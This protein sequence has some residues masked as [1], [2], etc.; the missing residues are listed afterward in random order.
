MHFMGL[1]SV[2]KGGWFELAPN[3]EFIVHV[4][5]AA[6]RLRPRVPAPPADTSDAAVQLEKCVPA[7]QLKTLQRLDER[8]S[9][10]AEK[11]GDYF[12]VD[13][14]EERAPF[15]DFGS[16]GAARQLLGQCY[17]PLE[18]HYNRRPCTW[19][20]VSR[21]DKTQQNICGV[22]KPPEEKALFEV[23]FLTCKFG[24]A[25]M[26]GPVR[27]LRIAEGTTTQSEVGLVWDPPE[28]DGGTPLRGY[29]VEARE[30]SGNGLADLGGVLGGDETPRTASAPPSAEPS[31]TLR[32]LHGNTAYVFCVWA[33]SEAG[34]GSGSEVEGQT[35]AVEPGLCGLPRLVPGSEA[36][37]E[38]Q[39]VEWDPPQESGGALIVAYRVWLRPLF[40]N[41]SGQIFPAEGWIDLGFFEH[42]GAQTEIQRSPLRLDALPAC[43]GCLC[44]LSALNSSGHTGPST[45]E[46]PIIVAQPAQL[47]LPEK[48][49]SLK[50]G[51]ASLGQEG[52]W[53]EDRA[54]PDLSS[55]GRGH[56]A[57]G[58]ERGPE[59]G[60]ASDDVRAVVSRAMQRAQELQE[61]LL[62][63]ENARAAAS[64]APHLQSRYPPVT[65][66]T[67]AA[68]SK[69][70]ISPSA[71]GGGYASSAALKAPPMT[72]P[73]A[74]AEESAVGPQVVPRIAQAS[75][76]VKKSSYALSA[77]TA[78]SAVPTDPLRWAPA[79]Y[80]EAPKMVKVESTEVLLAEKRAAFADAPGKLDPAMYQAAVQ[81]A[82][83]MVTEK[84]D[85]TEIQAMIKEA[86][87]L[88][89]EKF[90][91]ADYQAMAQEAAGL[92][93]EREVMAKRWSGADAGN[94]NGY[95]QT[96]T[97][98]TLTPAPVAASAY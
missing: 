78:L 39:Y 66:P 32:N 73:E 11:P 82:A 28:T 36:D 12:R 14:W 92:A 80:A 22:N 59:L 50:P 21:T 3:Y 97:T 33:V 42:R 61:A 5:G 15:F 34:P 81:E 77:G 10:R 8:L 47:D 51:T 86:A 65:L 38:A 29:R 83:G 31:A 45:P 49:F 16:K 13:V 27:N 94:G 75:S 88:T 44:S 24:L 89:T 79:Q 91:P 57:L 9:I 4:G 35:G 85:P 2:P 52:H 37:D 98:Q 96:L 71:V 95:G 68:I 67:A 18:K 58:R 56:E 6:K 63:G 53:L 30:M 87:G 60:S 74:F 23:G 1:S 70:D 93:T 84:L 41:S 46:E 43:S 26:P 72:R 40:H 17:V 62:Q 54:Q 55:D 20:I 76:P 64:Q 25:T 19:P 7:E 90:N 69:A 48:A